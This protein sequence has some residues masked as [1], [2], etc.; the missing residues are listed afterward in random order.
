MSSSKSIVD[1]V[2]GIPFS[3][4]TLGHFRP[5]FFANVGGPEI[6]LGHNFRP[7]TFKNVCNPEPP[8]LLAHFVAS[9]SV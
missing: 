7:E 8:G 2:A 3:N 1:R 6:L 5:L 4:C 9:E